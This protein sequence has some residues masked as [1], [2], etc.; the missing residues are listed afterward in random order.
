MDSIWGNIFNH[1]KKDDGITGTL[2]KVPLFEG[3][4]KKELSS[5]VSVLH[6]REYQAGEVVF[7]QG[8]LASGMYIV[9]HGTVSIIYEP[10]SDKLAELSQGEFFGELA[11]LG[12]AVRSAEAVAKTPCTLLG[13][14]QAD[15]F[16]IIERNP[17]LGVKIMSHLA[18][19]I[20]ERLKKSN[21]QV[22]SL[23]EELYALRSR[24]GQPERL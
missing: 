20:G 21:E 1:K 22:Q 3:L 18:N 15:L 10:T 8:V 14:F 7:H 6:R 4:N 13:F 9:L 11:L 17:M 23:R 12:D 2:K 19:I 24:P 16:G 5:V